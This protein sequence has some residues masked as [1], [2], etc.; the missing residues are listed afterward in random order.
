M[1]NRKQSF[2]VLL[3]KL[4][5]FYL[6]LLIVSIAL[7][8]FINFFVT[9]VAFYNLTGCQLLDPAPF[10]GISCEKSFKG[11]A[12]KN[13]YNFPINLVV[14]SI[15]GLFS[16]KGVGVLLSYWTPIFYLI[17]RRLKKRNKVGKSGDN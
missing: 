16:I 4:C 7:F 11:N 12:I 17:T 10:P 6:A 5:L 8:F 13:I 3:E 15:F 9:D 14:S 2:F 1:A